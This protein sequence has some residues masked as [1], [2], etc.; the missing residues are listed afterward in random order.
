[1]DIR[2][3]KILLIEDTLADADLIV[4]ILSE[5][6]TIDYQ[7][8]HVS[9]LS[10]ALAFLEDNCFDVA[11]LDLSLPD[12]QGLESLTQIRQKTQTIPTIVLTATNDRDLAIQAL[13]QGAQDYLVKGKLEGELLVRSIG[14]AIERQRIEETL[15]QQAERERL[16]GKMLERIR[17]SLDLKNIL[18]TTVEEVRQFLESDRVSIYYCEASRPREILADSYEKSLYERS[19]SVNPSILDFCTV[20]FFQSTPET[21]KVI[22]DVE[23]ANLEAEDAY[24]FAIHKI[25]SIVTFPIWRNPELAEDTKEIWA[26]NQNSDFSEEKFHSQLWG[27][28]VAHNYK[29]SSTWQQ[30]QIDFLQQLTTQVTIAIQQSELLEKLKHFNQKLHH[31]A[32]LDGLT[33]IANRREFDRI[34]QQEWQRLNREKKLMSLIMC[35]IDF[36]K[37]YNDT[38]GHPAGDFCLKQVAKVLQSAVK[39]SADLVARYGGEEFAIVLPD[40]DPEGALFVAQ[41]ILQ[42]LQELNI[43]HSASKI[44]PHVTLS[45]GVCTKMSNLEDKISTLIDTTDIALYQA[46]TEGRNRVNQ[47]IG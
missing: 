19:S 39:R 23:L 36:F 34:L 37:L 4:E 15:R 1:V 18:Q 12:S 47:I 9:S 17:R 26:T 30:W 3:L 16:M 33:G 40:T 38:Y 41:R 21:V 27:M 6:N 8:Q 10:R 28:L 7:V 13:R 2:S 43:P 22:P 46:K 32:T 31:L 24:L 45:I 29:N 11:L 5:V 14:Y 35:D 42:D 20:N 25:R 44:A